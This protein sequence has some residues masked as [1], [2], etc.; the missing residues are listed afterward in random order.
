[1]MMRLATGFA[2]VLIT[3]VAALAECPQVGQGTVKFTV[4]E[5]FRIDQS[6]HPVTAGGNID[7]GKCPDVPGSGWVTKLP[8]FVVNYKTKNGPSGFALTFRIEGSTDTVLLI[9]GPNGKWHFDDDGGNRLNGKIR[10]PQA[11]PG[12]YDIWVGSY[13]NKL[14]K[15]RL[16]ITELQ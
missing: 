10:F 11:S 13:T 1:M 3:T 5:G 7:L 8:D 9:N 4:E 6:V 12:R 14:S 16:E 2:A 15:A